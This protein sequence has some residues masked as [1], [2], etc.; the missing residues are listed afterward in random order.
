MQEGIIEKRINERI[1]E[2]LGRTPATLFSNNP[3]DS[4]KKLSI[5]NNKILMDES[6]FRFNMK[7]YENQS[8]LDIDNLGIKYS[9]QDFNKD[10]L[11]PFLANNV[12]V[13]YL[14]IKDYENAKNYFKLSLELNPSFRA[15]KLNLANLY[16]QSNNIPKALEIYGELLKSNKNDKGV[17]I[18]LG[19][20]YLMMVQLS[21]AENYFNQVWEESKN[22]VDVGNK[23]GLL[24]LLKGSFNKSIS[25]LRSCITIAPN[26]AAIYNT[27]GVAYTFGS[28][29]K[30]AIQAFKTS[31]NL[32]PSYVTALLNLSE[33]LIKNNKSKDALDLVEQYCDKYN[34]LLALDLLAR[35]YLH[36]ENYNR[37]LIILRKLYKSAIEMNQSSAEIARLLNNMGVVFH[38]TRDVSKAKQLYL[39]AL[40]TD[41]K[42]RVVLNNL[43]DISFSNNELDEADKFIETLKLE[44]PT[45]D[46]YLY[47]KA[48]Y[49]K[50]K[51]DIPNAIKHLEELLYSNKSHTSGYGL[52]SYIYS[53]SKSNYTK[54]IQILE[55][56]LQYLPYE[57]VIINDLAYNYLMAD[58]IMKAKEVLERAKN[59]EDNVFIIA[60]RGLLAIKE[61]NLDLGRYLYN[62]AINMSKDIILKH[63][64]E[65]KKNIE[66]ARHNIKAGAY[67]LA[68]DS[69]NK[70]LRDRTSI[71]SIQAKKLLEKIPN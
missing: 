33:V 70:V 44:I 69:L 61:N 6:D 38:R 17:L 43:I 4:T 20:I 8:T 51:G 25:I 12:G 62:R 14:G 9:L 65:Q 71:Y 23:L 19:N 60:T 56:G 7:T 66:V 34:D 41:K 39:E 1:I 50:E 36:N 10:K 28:L 37:S 27:L 32:S 21:K 57:E 68:S 49:Y 40:S 67:T 26:N 63:L 18:N 2:K 42:N 13:A 31:L 46:N 48:I 16:R 24:Y 29:D 22:D 11:N 3:F 54:A 59:I 5:T 15:A 52:L 55:T 30:K 53:E 47:Y 64:I 58:E 35:L 45:D